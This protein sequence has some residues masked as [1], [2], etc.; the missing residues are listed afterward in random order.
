M[1]VAASSER[2]PNETSH[3]IAELGRCRED[4]KVSLPLECVQARIWQTSR[5]LLGCPKRDDAIFAAVGDQ[6]RRRYAGE[7][8]KDSLRRIVRSRSSCISGS[9]KTSSV[10]N[11]RISAISFISWSR[12]HRSR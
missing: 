11:R 9:E 4:G 12:L 2:L 5:D 6:H 3:D 8:R 1:Q 10:C 7:K